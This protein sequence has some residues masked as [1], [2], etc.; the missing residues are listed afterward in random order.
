M[1]SNPRSIGVLAIRRAIHAA[2]DEAERANAATLLVIETH[3]REYAI[4]SAI[5]L[6]VKGRSTLNAI[7]LALAHITRLVRQHRK[8]RRRSDRFAVRFRAWCRSWLEKVPARY[9]PEYQT[10]PQAVADALGPNFVFVTG[11]ADPI[12]FEAGA[13]RHMIRTTHQEKLHMLDIVLGKKY[14][15]CITGFQ[16]VATGFCR[17]ISGCNQVLLVPPVAPD[18]AHRDG[19]W[20]D[21]QRC[22]VQPDAP[23]VLDNTA[24]P[25]CDQPAPKR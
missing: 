5:A 19:H 20:F 15:D 1:V 12:P 21:Q 25:G 23:V 16:G 14:I 4:G 22:I 13:R 24:T 17:Y 9:R 8:A 7:D 2:A 18:G 11:H 6:Y 3:Q 10:G